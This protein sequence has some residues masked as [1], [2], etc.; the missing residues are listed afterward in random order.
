MELRGLAKG[1]LKQWIDNVK[2]QTAHPDPETVVHTFPE[3]W[4]C[5]GYAILLDEL[6]SLL[7]GENSKK[8]CSGGAN[9]TGCTISL[10]TQEAIDIIT[11]TVERLGLVLTK[12]LVDDLNEEDKILLG[13]EDRWIVTI[14]TTP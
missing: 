11:P 4:A 14:T 5:I 1:Q 6:C 2:E 9:K 10:C 3:A 13:N 8:Y 7:D 12:E